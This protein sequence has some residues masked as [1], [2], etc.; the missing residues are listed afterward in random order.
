[1]ALDLD[2]NSDDAAAA[3]ERLYRRDEKWA[4][5]AKVLDRRAEISAEGGDPGRAA[6]IRRELA[7]LRAEKLG[8]LEGAIA[9]YEA[10]IAANGSDITALKALVD[11]YDKTGRTED[12]LRTMER[13]GAVAPEGEKLATLRKLAA[14]LEDRDPARAR[15]AYERM[16]AADPNADDAYRGLE[17]V[18]KAEANWYE[19]VAVYNRHI[20]AIKNPTARVELYLEAAQVHE[21]ELDDP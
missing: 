12:Y 1:H 21:R 13:L 18:L 2:E 10:A 5:L 16:L 19:L 4:N 9:R 15:E 11:L 17:R 14:E 3:L 8:D 20:A 7:T 6:A